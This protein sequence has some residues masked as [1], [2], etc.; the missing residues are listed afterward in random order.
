MEKKFTKKIAKEIAMTS[1]G[2]VLD[3]VLGYSDSG[4]T[5][6]WDGEDFEQNFDEDLKEL[7]LT[8]NERRIAIITKEFDLLKEKFEVYVRRKYYKSAVAKV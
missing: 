3:C 8:S 1:F 2:Y 7:G 5:L 4:Y 6:E